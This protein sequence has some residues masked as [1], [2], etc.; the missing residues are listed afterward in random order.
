MRSWSF[1]TCGRSTVSPPSAWGSIVARL[2]AIDADLD[3]R[4]HF[5][6]NGARS[7]REHEARLERELRLPSGLTGADLNRG[8]LRKPR[9]RHE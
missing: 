8:W 3:E 1:R 5:G 6:R 2:E 4:G 7:L 9:G